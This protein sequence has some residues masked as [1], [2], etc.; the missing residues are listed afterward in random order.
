MVA[1]HQRRGR[2]AS[3]TAERAAALYELLLPYAGTN[4]VIG[5]GAVCLGA[6]RRATW[7]AWR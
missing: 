6:T 1:L 5:L 7:G 2:D 4:V 3:A